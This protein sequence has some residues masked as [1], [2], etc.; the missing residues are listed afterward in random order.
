MRVLPAAKLFLALS[1]FAFG[2]SQPGS[3]FSDCSVCPEMTVIPAGSFRMGSPHDEADRDEDEGPVRTV[4]IAEPFAIGSYEVT[5][6]QFAAF[7]DETGH[8][9]RT[10]CLIWSGSELAYTD[11]NSW[12]DPGYEVGDDH[13]IVCVSWWDAVAYADWLTEKTGHRYRLPSEAEWEYAA[14]G[15]TQTA[16]SFP[17]GG[18]DEVC[19]YGN[20]SDL[21]ARAD[22]PQWNAVNCN[23]GVGLGTAPVGSYLPN[24]FG[25]YDTIGN[26]WEWQADCY[27]DNFTGAPV[28]GSAWG[29]GGNCNAV[30][31][32]GGGFS[33]I[34]PGHLRAANRS[35]APS[36]HVAVYS[37]GFRLVRELESSR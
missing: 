31:D 11:S 30:L 3:T 28:D 7:V 17:G 36:P 16:Y 27:R 37:L 33:N 5:R 22:V 8:R 13:P 29:H 19:S 18:P 24:G 26:V 20:V 35:R 2:S 9:G 6:R 1:A 14:R 15:G 34:F 10:G 21:G 12:L 32:R 4:T 25:L 23:D